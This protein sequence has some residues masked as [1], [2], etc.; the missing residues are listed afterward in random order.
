ML[1]EI[2]NPSDAV[3]FHAPDDKIARAVVL[4]LGGG[5]YGLKRWEDGKSTDVPCLL[6]FLPE[7]GVRSLLI[8]WFGSTDLKVF[9]AE[10]RTEIVAA[11]ES[12]QNVGPGK[13]EDYEAKLAAQPTAAKRRAFAKLYEDGHRSSM[14]M[15]TKFAWQS[16]K[17]VGKVA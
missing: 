11:L 2:I 9:L 5:K 13:R 3:T 6:L 15:I 1:Y 17:T 12:C 4:G 10:H 14:N 16:A 7:A 8:A